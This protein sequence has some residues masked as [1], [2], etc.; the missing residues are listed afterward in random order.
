MT[1]YIEKILNDILHHS[2][3]PFICINT[4]FSYRTPLK[5]NG[6]STIEFDKMR[7]CSRNY[8]SFSKDFETGKSLKQ[9]EQE[10]DGAEGRG[11][12]IFRKVMILNEVLRCNPLQKLVVKTLS[13]SNHIKFNLQRKE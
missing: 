2:M 8:S 10:E 1:R 12:D 7:D 13:V 3:V 4:N 11:G 5:R 9:I 6:F